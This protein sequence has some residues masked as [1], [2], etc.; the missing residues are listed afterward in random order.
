MRRMRRT[1]STWVVTATLAGCAATGGDQVQV[2][3][4]ELVPVQPGVQVVADAD[5]PLFFADGYYWLFRH[6]SWL[7]SDTYRGGF[8]Q[9]D[10]NLVPMQVRS[11]PSPA[12]YVHYRRHT[13]VASGP[14][15]VEPRTENAARHP[16][17][18]PIG[19]PEQKPPIANPIP[20]QQQPPTTN[21]DRGSD[22]DRSDGPD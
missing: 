15:Q 10:A 22:H 2:A 13:N 20:E 16:E 14:A 9:V 12:A 7:R 8:A 19:T 3:S 11:I 17:P 21:M 18:A 5:A 1:V 4:P 6:G